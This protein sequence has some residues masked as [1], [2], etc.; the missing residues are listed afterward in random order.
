[1]GRYDKIKVYDGTNFV[2]PNRIQV[3]DGTNWQDLGTNDS[4]NTKSLNVRYN[5]AFVRATLNK[6][7]VHVAQGSYAGGPFKFLPDNGFCICA[8]ASSVSNS[9]FIFEGTIFREFNEQ[10]RL[11]YSGNSSGS[12]KIEIWWLQDGRI[13][14]YTTYNGY[15]SQID[16]SNSV[17]VGQWVWLSV[18]QPM[19]SNTLQISFNGVVT[20]GNQYQNFVISNAYNTIGDWGVRFK[21]NLHIKGR[22][23]SGGSADKTVNM[24]VV[25]GSDGINYANVN[26]YEDTVDTVVWE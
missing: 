20:T 6:R 5:N 22:Q 15:S 13:R 1:M 10:K 24:S 9:D 14:V 16:S 4:S 12:A 8:N 7:I 23:Y 2:R 18:W 3:F 11:F 21:G 25:S 17:A 19:G 26:H